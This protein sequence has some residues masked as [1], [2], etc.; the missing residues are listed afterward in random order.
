MHPSG[1][2][3]Y[4]HVDIVYPVFVYFVLCI[5]CD[6]F[7]FFSLEIQPH[8]GRESFFH[9]LPVV[10]KGIVGARGGQYGKHQA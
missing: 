7:V 10:D 9:L 6:H 1:S 8:T 2:V 5:A 4:Q 3:E